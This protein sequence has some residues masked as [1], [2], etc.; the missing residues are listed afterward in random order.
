MGGVK[1]NFDF[2]APAILPSVKEPLYPFTRRMSGPHSWPDA[3]E[4]RKL[5]PASGIE[6]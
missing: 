5:W 4:K 2:K 3:T 1:V 6:C